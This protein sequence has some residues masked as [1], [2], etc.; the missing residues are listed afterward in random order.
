MKL[1]NR[2]KDL[3]SVV[4]RALERQSSK[5]VTKTAAAANT[6]PQFDADHMLRIREKEIQNSKKQIDVNKNVI[7]K[8]QEKLRGLGPQGTTDE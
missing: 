7:N 3:N 8:L 6:N 5:I 4:E 1:R 2:I